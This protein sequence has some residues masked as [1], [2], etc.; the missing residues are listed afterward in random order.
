LK[1]FSTILLI[2][3]LAVFLVAGS[4]N[5][6]PTLTL[7]DGVGNSVTITDDD[8]DG[9]V[10]YSGAIGSFIVNVTTGITK[11]LIG[12]ADLPRMDLNSINVSG[13][14]GSLT[15]E[16]FEDGFSGDK[17][18]GLESLIGGTTSGTLSAT[19]YIDATVLSSF[20]PFGPGAFSDQDLW[21]GNLPESFSLK[22]SATITQEA[23]DVTSFDFEVNSVPD[24][25]IMLL[26][27]PALLGLG[28]FGRKFNNS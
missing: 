21:S 28:V 20:G 2:S 18:A 22:I 8:F 1:K 11:P 15:I 26:L 27:G 3:F 23:G 24:A 12:S 19:S 16:F 10:V 25:S 5:A 7:D 6:T 14:N 4:A 17:I 9:V 13:G